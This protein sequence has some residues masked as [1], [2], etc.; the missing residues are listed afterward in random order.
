MHH[1]KSGKYFAF[2][3]FV[4]IIMRCVGNMYAFFVVVF[5][6]VNLVAQ[7]EDNL[8]PLLIL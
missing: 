4:Y 5:F 1:R 8:S 2:L 7:C 3:L 6:S